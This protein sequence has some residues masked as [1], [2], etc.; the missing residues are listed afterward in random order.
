MKKIEVREEV[1]AA[2]QR[3]ATG[4]HRTP[5]EVLSSLLNIPGPESPG[6]EPLARFVLTPE[7]RAKFTDADKYLAILRWIAVRHE[8]EFG[9][10]IRNQ[11]GG[12]RYLSMSRE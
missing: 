6:A 8:A 12:R 5:D 11:S 10:F 7:F 3:L 9:E 1:Y 2:L 4:F